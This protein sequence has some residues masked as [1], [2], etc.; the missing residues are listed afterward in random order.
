M[1]R[2][3]A[4]SRAGGLAPALIALL[5]QGLLPAGAAPANNPRWVFL[6]GALPNNP[7]GWGCTGAIA[8]VMALGFIQSGGIATGNGAGLFAVFA[9]LGFAV[10]FVV[11]AR[12]QWRAGDDQA[13]LTA[14][15][16]WLEDG[17]Q[18]SSASNTS[19]GDRTIPPELDERRSET[20]SAATR[21][22]ESRA[23]EESASFGV[24]ESLRSLKAWQQLAVVFPTI[25]VLAF[26]LGV[27]SPRSRHDAGIAA[28]VASAIAVLFTAAVLVGL[29]PK[30]RSKRIAV[31]AIRAFAILVAVLPL[32]GAVVVMMRE[33]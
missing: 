29:H 18:P 16:R 19:D 13:G 31:L 3:S 30:L 6:I 11:A 23:R 4:A 8:G 27:L 26:L 14:L 7:F 20:P 33:G 22:T 21:E 10:G 24:M 28:V 9:G 5:V 25:W 2:A 15:F 1:H 17:E 32:L 12:L